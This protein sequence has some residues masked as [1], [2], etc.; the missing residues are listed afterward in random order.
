MRPDNQGGYPVEPVRYGHTGRGSPTTFGASRDPNQTKPPP[1]PRAMESPP[2][3]SH[4]LTCAQVLQNEL[5]KQDAHTVCGHIFR[6][7]EKI[8]E[9][10]ASLA[11][12]HQLFRWVDFIS[13]NRDME[14]DWRVLLGAKLFYLQ[15][16]DEDVDTVVK[17]W[18]PNEIERERVMQLPSEEE[19]RTPFVWRDARTVALSYT[20]VMLNRPLRLHRPHR[21]S[22]TAQTPMR[23]MSSPAEWPPSS[24]P[25]SQLLHQPQLQA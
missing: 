18:W 25:C 2:I 12:T 15:Y 14:L 9:T 19:L 5:T 17:K 13:C 16:L 10:T 8:Q 6:L 1:P 3:P 22:S 20:G 11:D 24:T 7:R 4:C 21:T 23:Y